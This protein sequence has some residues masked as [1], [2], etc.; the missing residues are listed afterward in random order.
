MRR[1]GSGGE[2]LVGQARRQPTGRQ[3]PGL[4]A[5]S[6]AGAG[7]LLADALDDV[8]QL[9]SPVSVLA[10]ESDEL[11]SADNDGAAVRSVAD[12]DAAAAA[13]LEQSLVAQRPQRAKDRV[14]VDPEHESEV[15]SGRQPLT[16][17]GFTIGNRPAKLRGDLLME[18][19]LV[20][21]IDLEA[22][23]GASNTSFIS[24]GC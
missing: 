14:D 20:V 12:G 8:D 15:P 24:Y 1:P 3:A 23:H 22:K 19:N 17:L 13:E 18:L 2:N 16:R 6:P 11:A 10:R 9:V 4:P 7:A 5:A 21:A